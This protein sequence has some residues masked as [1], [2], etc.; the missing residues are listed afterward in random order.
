MNFIDSDLYFFSYQDELTFKKLKK[1]KKNIFYHEIKS[2]HGHD[3]FL[4]ENDIMSNILK[5]I[6]SQK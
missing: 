2:I 4:I 3:A 5:P 1:I 6:F